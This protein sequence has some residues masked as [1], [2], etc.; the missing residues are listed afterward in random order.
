MND[1]N[2]RNCL[3]LETIYTGSAVVRDAQTTVT[4][5]VTVVK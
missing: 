2:I 1:D 3:L 5:Q 4:I